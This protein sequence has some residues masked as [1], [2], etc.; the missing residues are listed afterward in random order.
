MNAECGMKD[1]LLFIPPSAFIVRRSAFPCY[2]PAV[3]QTVISS[4]Q[5]CL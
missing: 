2:H 5:I 4:I 1:K 3:L